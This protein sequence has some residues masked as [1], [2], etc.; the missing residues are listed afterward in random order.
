MM[1]QACRRPGRKPRQQSAMLM[2]ESALQRPRFTQTVGGLVSRLWGVGYGLWVVLGWSGLRLRDER[3]AGWLTGDG[4][5]EDG[6]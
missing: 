4:R 5:E 6:D 1:Y 3:V 2:R